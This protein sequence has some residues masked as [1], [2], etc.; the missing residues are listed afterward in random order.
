M[1]DVLKRRTAD[2]LEI[3][4]Q[5]SHRWH[6]FL[7]LAEQPS[8]QPTLKSK[9]AADIRELKPLKWPG[10]EAGKDELI[11][12]ALWTVLWDDHAQF[13][14]A[15]QAEA[16]RLA[17]AKQKPLVAILPVGRGKSLIFMVPAMLS[18]SGVTII[19]APYCMLS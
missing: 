4:G 19:I 18:G 6:K 8:S 17:T 3:F 5:V 12:K 10:A 16:V 11:L 9:G 1:I 7:K 2:S 15:Q 13:R 14:T